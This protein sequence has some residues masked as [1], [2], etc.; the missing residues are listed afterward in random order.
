MSNF[1]L[2]EN[3]KLVNIK[4]SVN[5]DFRDRINGLKDKFRKRQS[6][7]RSSMGRANRYNQLFNQIVKTSSRKG[8]LNTGK[9]LKQ[10]KGKKLTINMKR[11]TDSEEVSVSKFTQFESI[12]NIIKKTGTV[13]EPKLLRKL[14]TRSVNEDKLSINPARESNVLYSRKNSKLTLPVHNYY[15]RVTLETE[16][17]M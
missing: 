5:E 17:D 2:K 12:K 11:G 6:E 13:G 4:E 9:D 10:R 14:M 1:N 16:Q 15:I 8:S 7:N 3:V